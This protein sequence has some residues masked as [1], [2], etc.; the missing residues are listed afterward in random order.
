MLR[1]SIVISCVMALGAPSFA[2]T[3]REESCDVT[4]QI[5]SQAIVARLSG[6]SSDAVKET[7]ASEGS[8]FTGVYV[9]TIPPLVDM[10]F[11]MEESTLSPQAADTYKEQCLNY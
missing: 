6:Q 3:P 8:G 10:V 2:S 1:V 9:V 5:V 4:S 7:L 11:S